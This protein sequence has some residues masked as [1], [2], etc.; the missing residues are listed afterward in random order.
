MNPSSVAAFGR[1]MSG[2]VKRKYS[3]GHGDAAT[4]KRGISKKNRSDVS[5]R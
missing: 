2:V 3:W 1:S 5:T 4:E